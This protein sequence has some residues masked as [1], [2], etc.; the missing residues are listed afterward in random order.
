MNMCGT[1][2]APAGERNAPE[3]PLRLVQAEP[4]IHGLTRWNFDSPLAMHTEHFVVSIPY[5]IFRAEQVWL[6]AAATG[7]E[8]ASTLRFGLGATSVSGQ[9]RRV[10]GVD[11]RR[12]KDALKQ[13]H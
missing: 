5:P 4:A 3:A 12:V 6:E 13:R 2:R 7:V 9:E 1:M 11:S 8:T 10:D